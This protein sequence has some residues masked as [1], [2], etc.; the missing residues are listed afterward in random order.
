MP[1]PRTTY[2]DRAPSGDYDGYEMTRSLSGKI[3]LI[4]PEEFT[5]TLEDDKGKRYQ[6][7]ISGKIKLKADKKTELGEKKELTLDDFQAGQ[8]VKITYW[9]STKKVAEIRLRADDKS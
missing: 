8:S 6:F 4:S 5:L 7:I 1:P 3:A 9:P 2:G